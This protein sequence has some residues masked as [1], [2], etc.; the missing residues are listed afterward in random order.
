MAKVIN[1]DELVSLDALEELTDAEIEAL[2]SSTIDDPMVL[3][4]N[5]IKMMESY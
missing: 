4:N 5:I 3:W 1:G 2:T